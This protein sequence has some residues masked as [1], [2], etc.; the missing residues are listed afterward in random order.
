MNREC[1]FRQTGQYVVNAFRAKPVVRRAYQ[2]LQSPCR[3]SKHA[4]PEEW[5]SG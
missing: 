3:Y 4:S 1:R 5:Q 2:D